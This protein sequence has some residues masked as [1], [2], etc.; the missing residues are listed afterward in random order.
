MN[1]RSDVGLMVAIG[2]AAAAISGSLVFFGMQTAGAGAGAG[3]SDDAFFA[4]VEEGIERYVEKMEAEA[5]AAQADAIAK[6]Q[7][8]TKEQAKRVPAVAAGKDHVLGN[9]NAKISL[10]EYSDFRCPFCQ[11][12]HSTPRQLMEEYGDDVNWVYRHFPLSSH[13]PEATLQA[14]ASECVAELG[15]NDAFWEYTDVLF[16]KGPADSA[17]LAAAAADLGVSTS[18]FNECLESERHVAKVKSDMSSGAEAGVTGTPG[19]IVLNNETGAAIL[20]S[21]A[22]DASKFKEAIDELLNA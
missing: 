15:G 20:V 13:D 3:M 5:Q 14:S 4:K 1:K 18:E 6:E 12:F 22:Q 8:R 11:R 16:T 17:S 21:G 19:T 2:F 10:I 7:E 9:P